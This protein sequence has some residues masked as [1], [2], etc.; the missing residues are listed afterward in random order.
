MFVSLYFCIQVLK[1]PVCYVAEIIILGELIALAN[2]FKKGA[3]KNFQF[4]CVV[5]VYKNYQT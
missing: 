5:L 3:K 4:H 1:L 2:R